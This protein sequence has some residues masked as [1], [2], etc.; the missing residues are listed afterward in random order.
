MFNLPFT[1]EP[2]LSYTQQIEK[3]VTMDDICLK[4]HVYMYEVNKFEYWAL[5]L[6][7]ISC[8]S[9]DGVRG[10]ETHECIVFW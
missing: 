2:L 8:R 10:G 4:S 3:V 1:N 7:C 5:N 6:M 9:Y